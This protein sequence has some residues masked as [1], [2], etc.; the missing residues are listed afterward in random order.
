MPEENPKP[1]NGLGASATRWPAKVL[2]GRGFQGDKDLKVGL[3]PQQGWGKRNW[4]YMN[5]VLV[6]EYFKRRA[7]MPRVENIPLIDQEEVGVVWVG[8]ATFLLQIGGKHVLVD[9]NWANWLGF[10]KRV[11]RPG[12]HIENLPHIDLVLITHAHYDHLH[13]GSLRKI[14]AGQPIVVPK[15]VGSIVNKRG[16]GEVVELDCWGEAELDGLKVTM[17]PARHWGARM[18]HDTHR[19]FGGYV[20]EAGNRS[21]YHC[22]DSA[23]FDGFNEIGERFSEIDV[24]L[25]PIGAYGAM[26]GREVHMNPEEAID[27]FAMVGARKLI[28]MHYAT[29][30]LGTEPMDEPLKRLTDA[31]VGAGF[32]D[33]LHVLPEGEHL[34]Y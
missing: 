22:G 5:R 32:E 4:Q 14:A 19:Q 6:P 9:P 33:H 27:A 13:V 21:I 1:P 28:P 25:M 31:A 20:L 8:H 15:G 29:F 11:R 30:P 2:G 18:I 34:I 16:F 7:G 24:A 23:F 3:L 10:V 17:T 12:L 26:S